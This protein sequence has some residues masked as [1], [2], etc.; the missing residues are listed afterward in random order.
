MV[1]ME[2]KYKDLKNKNN[3]CVW[4]S[5]VQRS[6]TWSL[7]YETLFGLKIFSPYAGSAL[8][9]TPITAASGQCELV[10]RCLEIAP[11]GDTACESRSLFPERVDTDH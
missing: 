7:Q 2:F 8:P 6:A 5:H 10:P 11:A 4:T 3:I 1:Y 9:V